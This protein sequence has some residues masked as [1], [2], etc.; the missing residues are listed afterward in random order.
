MRA[1]LL[2]FLLVLA[3]CSTPA[4][5][6]ETTT[7]TTTPSTT[8]SIVATTTTEPERSEVTIEY[9]VADLPGL[10]EEGTFSATGAAVDDGLICPDGTTLDVHRE[11]GSGSREISQIVYTCDDGSGTF[12]IESE[13]TLRPFP[14]LVEESGAWIIWEGTGSGAYE[15]LSG[16]GA[17]T[18]IIR[19]GE[20][21][22]GLI[23]HRDASEVFTGS[24]TIGN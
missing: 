23:G 7:T 14:N 9:E 3:A 22:S 11:A 17:M 18:G 12:T 5:S 15:Q 19:L 24:V 8:T 2:V 16:S 1:V 21:D 10:G 4:E 13:Y 6:A 20:G